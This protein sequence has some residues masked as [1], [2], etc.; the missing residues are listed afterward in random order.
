MRIGSKWEQSKDRELAK[1][2]IWERNMVDSYVDIHIKDIFEYMIVAL[3]IMRYRH[4]I[5]LCIN[6][7]IPISLC[8]V[9]CSPMY[10][11][12]LVGILCCLI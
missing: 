7:Y 2:R 3:R 5:L 4:T 10:S 6:I 9:K 1:Q 12:R 11:L 8:G